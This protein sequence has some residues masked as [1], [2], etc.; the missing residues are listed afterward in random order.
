MRY[1]RFTPEFGLWFSASS[2]LSL[3]G[4]SDADYAGCRT[5]RKSTSGTCQFLGSSLVPW[6]SRKQS[7]IAQSTTEAEYVAAVACCSQLLWMV[8]T[9]W[10]YG[11]EFRRVPLF[12]DSTNAICVAKNPHSPLQ[13]QAHRGLFSLLAR[14]L[15]ENGTLILFMLTPTTSS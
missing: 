2:S 9:L 13:N 12:C 8:A 5:K 6:S 1:L 15:W 11:L 10:D 14:P 3:C 7:T 4:Y